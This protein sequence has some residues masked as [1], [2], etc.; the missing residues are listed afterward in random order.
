MNDQMTPM[1]SIELI[2]NMIARTRSNLGENRFYFLLWGW[3][4]FSALLVQFVLKALIHYPYHYL[5]WLLTIPTAVITVWHARK[6]HFSGSRTYAGDSMNS[7][8]TGVGISI[9]L[10]CVIIAAGPVGWRYAYPYFILLYGL[11]TFVS[12]KV[13][14]FRPLIVGGI[15]NWVLAVVCPFLPYDYQILLAALALLSSYIILGYLLKNE[16]RNDRTANE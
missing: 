4:V 15:V 16:S 13:L 7:L 14:Q 12:G 6:K 10:L 3:V 8:W 9:F 1:Q 2:Q 11:G 5:V